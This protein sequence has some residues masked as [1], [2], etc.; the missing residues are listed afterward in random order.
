VDSRHETYAVLNEMELDSVRDRGFL[1]DEVASE[2]F[3]WMDGIFKL[4]KRKGVILNVGSVTKNGHFRRSGL[5]LVSGETSVAVGL[6]ESA[7]ELG[8]EA[9]F[10]EEPTSVGLHLSDSAIRAGLE[11]VAIEGA[12]LA[13]CYTHLVQDTVPKMGSLAVNRKFLRTALFDIRMLALFPGRLFDLL[14]SKLLHRGNSTRRNR[15]E[16]S[17]WRATRTSETSER[18]SRTT[19]GC[20]RG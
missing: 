6:F 19:S 10:P 5:A 12:T 2:G 3:S 18:R 13:S 15:S 14:C 8:A 17:R 11:P 9:L 20:R 4:L 7:I 16:R 1:M